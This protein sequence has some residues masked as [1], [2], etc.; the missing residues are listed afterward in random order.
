[1]TPEK[2][3]ERVVVPKPSLMLNCTK[4]HSEAKGLTMSGRE[5]PRPRGR[6]SQLDL[7][8]RFERTHHEL[9]LEQVEGDD[10]YLASLEH[11]KTE[12]RPDRS[13]SIVSENDS[14]DV[15]FRYSINPYRGCLHGCSYCYSTPKSY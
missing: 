14:P 11:R 8:N 1:M 4:E 10:E 7:P 12:Y 9:D 2:L 5:I 3:Q 15:G 13:R 6:G